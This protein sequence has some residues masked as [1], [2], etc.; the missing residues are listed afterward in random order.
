MFWVKRLQIQI[1]RWN[2]SCAMSLSS[3]TLARQQRS[4]YMA[5]I[6][7]AKPKCKPQTGFVLDILHLLLH[8]FA[9]EVWLREHF[10]CPPLPFCSNVRPGARR[11]CMSSPKACKMK[12]WD[13]AAWATNMSVGFLQQIACPPRTRFPTSNEQGTSHHFSLD[14]GPSIFHAVLGGVQQRLMRKIRAGL[15]GFSCNEVL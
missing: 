9:C 13:S 7:N 10:N 6:R 5:H 14:C 4:H 1:H 11:L 2:C 15:G 3:R 8:G 12:V